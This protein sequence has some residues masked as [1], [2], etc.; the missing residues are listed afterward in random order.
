MRGAAE[1]NKPPTKA[2][3]QNPFTNLAFELLKTQKIFWC[4]SSSPRCA[5]LLG[6]GSPLRGSQLA[7]S[8]S[9]WPQSGHF[10][11]ITLAPNSIRSW[12]LGLPFQGAAKSTPLPFCTFERALNL[13]LRIEFPTVPNR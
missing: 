13:G 9:Q 3:P 10:R 1:G 8:G 2:G 11:L 6:G 4:A 12:G 5:G 7:A